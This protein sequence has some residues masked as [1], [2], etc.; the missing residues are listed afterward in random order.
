MGL[1]QR[2][3]SLEAVSLVVGDDGIRLPRIA[4]WERGHRRGRSRTRG[5]GA[6][7]SAPGKARASRSNRCRRRSSLPAR[8]ECAGVE[9]SATHPGQ[10]VRARV[11][12]TA[13]SLVVS[14]L[15]QQVGNLVSIR[16]VLCRTLGEVL[17]AAGTKLLAIG[18]HIGQS[19]LATNGCRG[20]GCEFAAAP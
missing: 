15:G 12:W 8:H 14:G 10:F 2:G 17:T 9:D 19:M 16:V 7:I 4:A 20:M 3:G 6:P 1:Q 18:Q 13:V 5:F 11:P